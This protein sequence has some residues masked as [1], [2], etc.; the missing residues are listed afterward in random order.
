MC[1][2]GSE[3]S[4]GG[5]SGTTYLVHLP[6]MTTPED[7]RMRDFK[8]AREATTA[9]PASPWRERV[10]GLV[11]SQAPGV[12]LSASD[13]RRAAPRSEVRRPWPD[14]RHSVRLAH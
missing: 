11:L 6:A 7:G 8:A 12:Y 13:R 4:R 2:R 10:R 1:S 5:A 14:P 9:W 3:A